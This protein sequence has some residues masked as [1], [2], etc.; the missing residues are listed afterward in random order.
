MNYGRR[1]DFKRNGEVWLLEHVRGRL[2]ARP[3]I[4]DGGAA[5]GQYTAE[6]HRVYPNAIVHCFEPSPVSCGRLIEN[7]SAYATVHPYAL[8]A[9]DGTAVLYDFTDYGSGSRFKR[10]LTHHGLP[11]PVE[12]SIE[13]RRLDGILDHVDFLKLDVEG[14]EY[15]ALVG[16]GNLLPRIPVIQF[17]FG[18]T[19]IDARRYLR[20]YWELLTPTHTL[21]RL[22]PRGL[23]ELGAYSERLEVFEL[24]NYVAL[25][26]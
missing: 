5:T 21:H 10:N 9:D 22:L 6:A 25:R 26:R 8:A 14:G 15:D 3:V 16:S 11:D 2:P 23:A 4:V 24:A 18:G 13:T 17:E 7:V 20:D 19:A 1:D 12:S